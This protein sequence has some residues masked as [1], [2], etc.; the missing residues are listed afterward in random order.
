M[1]RVR[2]EPP[3]TPLRRTWSTNRATPAHRIA[4]KRSPGHGRPGALAR[5]HG[6]PD[7]RAFLAGAE[8]LEIALV[9]E[10][11]FRPK[12]VAL[13]GVTAPRDR[14]MT[15]PDSGFVYGRQSRTGA[16][17]CRAV[18]VLVTGAMSTNRD[19]RSFQ[20]FAFGA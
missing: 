6:V 12:P 1:P 15:G 3:T 11:P 18:T 10:M 9:A 2:P 4:A 7:V 20:T 5:H 16:K 13:G 17:A 8:S 19:L 14:Q